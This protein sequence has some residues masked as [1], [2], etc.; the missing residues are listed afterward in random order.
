M[1]LCFLRQQQRRK[2]KESAPVV[3]EVHRRRWKGAP[4]EREGY[5]N[6]GGSRVRLQELLAH[7]EGREDNGCIGF[8]I[9]MLDFRKLHNWSL[10]VPNMTP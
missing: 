3:V 2:E 1:W 9:L 6:N 5:R 4:A 10:K 7:Q 8:P